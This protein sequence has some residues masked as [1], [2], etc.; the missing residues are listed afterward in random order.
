MSH[1]ELDLDNGESKDPRYELMYENSNKFGG[2]EKT[3]GFIPLQCL[4]TP[5]NP[6]C[7]CDH[8][9]GMPEIA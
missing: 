6:E 5:Y 8:C 4:T 3:S 9:G 2:D 7:F 1:L